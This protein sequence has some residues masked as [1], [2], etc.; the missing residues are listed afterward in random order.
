MNG[1]EVV[2][3]VAVLQP[4]TVREVADL[5]DVSRGDASNACRRAWKRGLLVRRRRTDTGGP[6]RT[7][8]EYALA[9]ISAAADEAADEAGDEA[10]DE[11]T[12]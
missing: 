1:G 3:A 9:D 5:F 12:A 4:A 8:F 10:A 2:W 7:P 11:A 6:G